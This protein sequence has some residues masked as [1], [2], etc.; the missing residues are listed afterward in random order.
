MG[1]TLKFDDNPNDKNLLRIDT[2]QYAEYFKVIDE[3][4]ATVK[5]QLC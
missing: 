5:M 4:L 3:S 2:S 1:H